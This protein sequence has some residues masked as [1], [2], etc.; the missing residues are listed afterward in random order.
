TIAHTIACSDSLRKVPSLP[1]TSSGSFSVSTRHDLATPACHD[2]RA[3]FFGEG[4]PA[5]NE[6]LNRC[7]LARRS[8]E[9]RDKQHSSIGKAALGSEGPTEQAQIDF[10]KGALP[11]PTDG[12]VRGILH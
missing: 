9:I 8:K 5:A 10:H 4:R 7:A 12:G 3:G 2:Q 6:V 11:C 1:S